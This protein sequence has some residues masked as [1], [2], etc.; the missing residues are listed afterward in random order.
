VAD[1]ELTPRAREIVD[2]ARQILER[3]GPAA[4]SM[5]A[6]AGRLGIRA[7]SLYKHFPDK[8]ALEAALVSDALAEIADLFAAAADGAADPLAGIG[9]AYRAW[10]LDHPHLY[11]LMMDRPLPRDRLV[12]GVEDRAASVVVA[13]TGGDQDAARAAFA[14]AHGMVILELNGR[15]PPAADL[16]AAWQRGIAAFRPSAARRR[17]VGRPV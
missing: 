16:D 11:R 1:G 10:A 3:G 17:A 4:L 12:P 5:R 8:E 13:A 14:F 6:I 2:A 7:P 9:R 15:F